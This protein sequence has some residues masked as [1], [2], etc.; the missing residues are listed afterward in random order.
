MANTQLFNGDTICS[1]IHRKARGLLA[2]A[3]A[4]HAPGQVVDRISQWFTV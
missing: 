1:T 2:R 4:L 3:R